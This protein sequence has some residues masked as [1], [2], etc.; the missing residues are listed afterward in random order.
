M[1]AW[2]DIFGRQA[3]YFAAVLLFTIGTIVCCTAQNVAA[4]MAGRAIQGL[5]G[6][7]IISVQLIILSDIIPL[8]QLP[9]YMGQCQLATGIGTCLAPIVGGALVKSTWRWLFYINLPFC[10]IGLA[11]PLLLFRY[12][13]P[14]TTLYDKLSSIDW[15]GSAIFVVGTTSFLLG[16]SWGGN[17]YIWDSVPTLIPLIVG[18][19]TVV[20]AALY[21]RFVAKKPFLRFSIF[22]RYSS[23]LC[24]ICA[25]FQALIVRHD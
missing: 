25:V 14:E 13:M 15:I 10:A 12:E 1:A 5:G 22:N 17:Q 11:I 3:T 23:M 19:A 9:K 18:L 7:G 20:M 24:S 4:M 2:A 21:E 8:R 6:G 16:I